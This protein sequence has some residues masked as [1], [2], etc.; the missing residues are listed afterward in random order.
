M[1]KRVIIDA[2]VAL[3]GGSAFAASEQN[4]AAALALQDGRAVS[5]REAVMSA[6]HFATE[7]HAYAHGAPGPS[8][9]EVATLSGAS[10]R[11][12]EAASIGQ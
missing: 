12:S 3:L 8:T 11:Q 6:H 9:A 10:T 4:H 2:A 1:K 7:S 5:L